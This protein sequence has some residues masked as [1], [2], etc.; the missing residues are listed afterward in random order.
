MQE[1]DWR[2]T[3]LVEPRPVCKDGA[4]GK[5]KRWNSQSWE[6]ALH[7]SKAWIIR[8]SG[9]DDVLGKYIEA[10]KTEKHQRQRST[11]H[12]LIR[13]WKQRCALKMSDALPLWLSACPPGWAFISSP[14]M[15]A[16][17]FTTSASWQAASSSLPYNPGDRRVAWESSPLVEPALTWLVSRTQWAALSEQ[18]SV[19]CCWNW[20]CTA[21]VCLFGCAHREDRGKTVQQ[22][23]L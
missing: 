9:K 16:E 23:D 1:S 3:T 19:A 2:K 15:A 13:S 14:A 22:I 7:H 10:N 4:E 11:T 8:S 12:V 6:S 5:N 20:I 17:P 18:D 21:C